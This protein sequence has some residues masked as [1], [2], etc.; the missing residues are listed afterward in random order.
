MDNTNK[1]AVYLGARQWLEWYADTQAEMIPMDGKAYLLA[2]RK[3]FYNAHHKKDILER[4][5]VAK[6]EASIARAYALAT[7]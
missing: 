6:A 4:H 7:C 2:G 3:A 1:V 5:R